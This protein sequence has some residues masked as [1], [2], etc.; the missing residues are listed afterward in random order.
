MDHNKNRKPITLAF[1]VLLMDLAKCS[2]ESLDNEY[3]L[4]GFSSEVSDLGNGF[5]S[6]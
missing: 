5:S 2:L 3:K 1:I 4:I 6:P